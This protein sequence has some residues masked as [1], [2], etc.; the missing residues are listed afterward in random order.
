MGM[1]LV[2]GVVAMIAVVLGL[3]CFARK[4][5]AQEIVLGARAGLTLSA[6]EFE[7]PYASEQIGV[8]K[9]LHLGGV[10]SVGLGRFLDA[11]VSVLMTQR[12]FL[13]AGAHP[14]SF[15]MDYLEIPAVLKV[16]IPWRISPHLIAGLAVSYQIRCR[17]TDVVA[18][19]STG[20]DDEMVGMEWHG[21]D[22]AGVVGLGVSH[23]FRNGSLFLDIT[24]A[25]GLRDLKVEPL[26]P[27]RARSV[28]ILFSTGF[29]L[30]V[31]L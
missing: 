28:S 8:R 9:G 23:P 11:E 1:R 7:D 26:P 24:G 14:G 15:K 31:S 13:D 4:T 2:L 19:Q 30:P 5:A 18:V 29:A 16:G 12:G 21:L 20:C 3:A 17:V 10:A 6:I 25:V 27:G 22:V